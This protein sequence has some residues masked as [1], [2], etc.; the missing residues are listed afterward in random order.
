[1]EFIRQENIIGKSTVFGGLN[2]Y[3]LKVVLS[4]NDSKE[5]SYDQ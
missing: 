1:M 3:L 2:K 5:K 4:E